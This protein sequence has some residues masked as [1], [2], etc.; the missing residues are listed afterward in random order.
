M[1][2]DEG[3]VRWFG[4]REDWESNGCGRGR[5]SMMWCRIG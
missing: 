5:G 4:E 3:G 2:R 1:V